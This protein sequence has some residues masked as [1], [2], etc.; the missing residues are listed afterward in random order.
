[1]RI[2]LLFRGS[3]AS[4]KSTFIGDKVKC[5][6]RKTYFDNNSCECDVIDV[7]EKVK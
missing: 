7:I 5:I 3:P 1:M 4:G 6:Y 2:L